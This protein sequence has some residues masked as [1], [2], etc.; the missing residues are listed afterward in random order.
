[1]KGLVTG[2]D[3]FLD[4]L[5]AVPRSFA[6]GW[7]VGIIVPLASLAGIVSG[8]YLLTRKVPFVTEIDEQDGGR[9]LV[10]QLVE[11]EQAKELLQRGRDAAREFRDEIRAEVEGEF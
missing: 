9:R 8:V 1:M 11:P 2:F 10:V 5:T 3:S 4:E 7:L 6:F